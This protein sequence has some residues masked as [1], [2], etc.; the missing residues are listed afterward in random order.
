MNSSEME[1]AIG[2]LYGA[3]DE[4]YPVKTMGSQRIVEILESLKAQLEEMEDDF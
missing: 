2:T 1:D 4:R 3:Q